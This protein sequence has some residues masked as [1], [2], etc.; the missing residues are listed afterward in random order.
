MWYFDLQACETGG[1]FALLGAMDVETFRIANYLR[2]GDASHVARK[3]LTKRWP[4]RAHNHDYCEVFLIES[5][6]AEHWINGRQE[7]LEPGR[8]NFIRP[9]DAHAFR[10]DQ[11]T[12]CGIINVMLHLET[13]EHVLTRYPETFRGRYFDAAGEIPESHLLSGTRMERAIQLAQQLAASPLTLAH[14]DEFLLTLVNR[15]VTPITSLNSDVPR[16]F[17][18]ACEDAR[19][20]D[21]F[22]RGATG[23][24]EAA[25]RSHEH[26]CRTCRAVL[27]LTP[28]AFINRIRTEFAADRLARSGVPIS[29]IAAECGIE[30]VSHFYRVFRQHYGTTPRAY[31]LHHQRSPF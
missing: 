16:W 24:I 25:G 14:L 11:K 4:E 13:A 1:F 17:A 29:Q 12:G 22:K 2:P 19:R 5:G 8:L 21:V 10:A 18:Q 20:P 31:R 28:S 7:T 27:G 15:V 30:N 9:T 3:H 6:Q 23:F 26:V